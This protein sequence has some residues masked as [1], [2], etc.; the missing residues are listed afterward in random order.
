M[1]APVRAPSPS[2]GSARALPGSAAAAP[3][4]H[5]R[6][7]VTVPERS[8]APSAQRAGTPRRQPAAPQ[9]KPVAQPALHLVDGRRLQVVARRHRARAALIAGGLLLVASLFGVVVSHAVLVSGQGRLDGL[10]QEVAEEQSRY[11]AL[12]LEVAELEAPGRIVE[13]AQGRLGM[14]NPPEITYLTPVP[15]DVEGAAPAEELEPTATG[16]PWSTVKPLLGAQG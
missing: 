12:R 10:Q 9:V 2:R 8:S 3:S 16:D 14:V 15:P 5:P 13:E 7:K 6:P 1:T 4:R 11:Q